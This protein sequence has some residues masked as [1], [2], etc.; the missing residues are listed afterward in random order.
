M[1]PI[2]TQKNST[3]NGQ[4]LLAIPS[5]CETVFRE[6]NKQI[7]YCKRQYE[8]LYLLIKS[9]LPSN[10]ME[11]NSRQTFYLTWNLFLV[12]FVWGDLLLM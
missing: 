8:N 10:V 1:L 5:I 6:H 12:E 2:S 7:I 9:H 11:K 3:I 4:Q